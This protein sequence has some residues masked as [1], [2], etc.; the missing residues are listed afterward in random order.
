MKNWKFTT[1]LAGS[2]IIALALAATAAAQQ[3]RLGRRA[4][5]NDAADEFGIRQF[6]SNLQLSQTQREDIKA[7]LKTHQ[8][9]ILAVRED[10]LKARIGILNKDPNAPQNFGAVQ[11]RIMEL[12]QV[13][14]SQIEAKLT[15]DQLSTLQKM[16]QRQIDLLNNRLQR[17][18]QR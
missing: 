4:L 8:P 16:R 10:L 9:E 18:E 2:L 15:A 5:N 1:I 13:I 14:A 3:G 7:I 17:L 12:R 11:T 6:V